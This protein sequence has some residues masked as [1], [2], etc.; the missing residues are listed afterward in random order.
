MGPQIFM[1][2]TFISIVN[3]IKCF[4]QMLNKIYSLKDEKFLVEEKNLEIRS[5]I[6]LSHTL[7]VYQWKASG[8]MEFGL[9]E[10]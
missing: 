2:A 4:G 10:N 6:F 3:T 9:Y 1:C 7:L 8:N 5:F